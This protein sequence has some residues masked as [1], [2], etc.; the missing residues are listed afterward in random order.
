MDSVAVL[1]VVSILHSPFSIY[2]RQSVKPSI[3]SEVT[4]EGGEM[5]DGE[6]LSGGKVNGVIGA[7]RVL[8]HQVQS[9][10]QDAGEKVNGEGVCRVSQA[11][12]KSLISRSL[13]SV[14][15]TSEGRVACQCLRPSSSEPR[16]Q[17]HFQTGIPKFRSQQVGIN[18]PSRLLPASQQQTGRTRH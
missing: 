1:K 16:S 3:A 17:F 10:R 7:Q 5:R 15:C 12:K 11:T 4:V 18:R 2:S 6:I 9:E 13:C 14:E 8:A